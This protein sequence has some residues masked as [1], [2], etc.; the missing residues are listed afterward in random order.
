MSKWKTQWDI[1]KA[2]EDVADRL[3]AGKVSVEQAQFE[4]RALNA[5]N[6]SFALRLEHARLT[7]RL[8]QGSDVLPDTQLDP[9]AEPTPIRQIGKAK[10]QPAL[11]AAKAAGR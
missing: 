9:N 7:G 3:K 10:V 1:A 4:L 6:Q 11:P 2:A 8:Q 5:A